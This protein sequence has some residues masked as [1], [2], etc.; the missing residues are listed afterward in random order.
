M[1]QARDILLSTINEGRPLVLVLGHDAWRESVVGDPVLSLALDHLKSP[2][3]SS[4]GWYAIF[5]EKALPHTF[6]DW[7]SE[8][9]ERRVHPNWFATL[10][11]VPWSAIFTSTLDPTFRKAL[12]R[13]GREPE[14][15]LTS[16]EKPRAV[17]SQAR[18]PLYYLFSHAGSHDPAALPPRTYGDFSAR[19]AAHAIP[20]LNRVMPTATSLGTVVIEGFISGSDWVRI[21]ELL[22]TLGRTAKGQILWFGGEPKN[23]SGQDSYVFR[24]AVKAGQ[25]IVEQTRLGTTLAALQA[26]NS[27]SNIDVPTWREPGIVS[28]R[29]G[30]YLETKPDERLRVEAVASIVDDSWTG[31]LHPLEPDTKYDSF[32]RFHGGL[33]G[34]RL[35]VEG[36]L[37]NFSIRRD[38][39]DKLLS[40]V[41]SAIE[42]HAHFDSPIIVHGQSG[43]G[44]SVALARS[45]AHVR[46]NRSA[47]VL[48][49][50]NRVPQAQEVAN[51]CER[52]ERAGAAVTLIVCDTNRSVDLYQDLFISLRSSGR[53]VVLV[54]SRYRILASEEA[55]QYSVE[56]EPELS[57]RERSELAKLIGNY[58]DRRVDANSLNNTT[59]FAFLYRYLPSTRPR[60]G[61]G[62]GKEARFTEEKIRARGRISHPVPSTTEIARQLIELGLAT[63]Y[64]PLFSKTTSSDQVDNPA[65]LLV[66]LVMVAGRLNCSVPLGLL[67]RTVV[68]SHAGIDRT[69]IVE[70]FADLDL[71]RWSWAD[72]EHSD[73][74]V[75]PRLALEA[76]LICDRRLGNR[77]R[78]A[79]CLVLLISG[80]RGS[81]LESDCEIR[82]LVDLLQQIGESGPTG[83]R[84]HR[85]YVKVSR[86]LT[87]LRTNGILHPSLVLQES[88]FRRAAIRSQVVTDDESLPLLEEARDA[89]QSTLEQV[90]NG[91]LLAGRRTYEFLLVER[92]SLYGYLASDHARR[93]KNADE[94][95]SAYSAARTAIRKASN[96]TNHYYP[97]DV[98]LWTPLDLLEKG[99]LSDL[100]QADLRADIYATVD[101]VDTKMLP[102]SQKE[103]FGRRRMQLGKVLD[104]STLSETAYQELMESGS[105]AGFF[106]RAREFLPA[107][108]GDNLVYDKIQISQAREGAE[109]LRGHFDAIKHDERC[110]YLL[111]ECCWIAEMGRRPLRGERQ[112]LPASDAARQNMLSIVRDLNYAADGMGSHSGRYLE[113]V[114][115]WCVGN[116]PVA[117]DM[118][119]SLSHETENL[120]PRRVVRRHIIS[121]EKFSPVAFRGRVERRLSP[122]RASVRVESLNCLVNIHSRDFAAEDLERGREVRNFSI[123]FNFIGAIAE[124]MR[125]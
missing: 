49:A 50:T 37:R 67:I 96:V 100:Q 74:L 114:L 69:T 121:D 71:F 1:E 84:Y 101:Q 10:A 73:F 93:G 89:V 122:N 17:R 53:R 78:E 94:I 118:F 35:L 26:L 66:D 91:S 112:P 70:M 46:K 115:N 123:A 86:A 116:V 98:G 45:V 124:P 111:L 42:D 31:F 20:M 23:L 48:Y 9:F 72:F 47:A 39:E 22:G 12:H 60:F 82:F 97:L 18:P 30:R 81:D 25:I 33:G 7:L 107:L 64:K 41:D 27:L 21:D 5:S 92:A 87:A 43:T 125:K 15:I 51:F 4:S 105:T 109:F 61:T 2:E 65:G 52:A 120:D 28:F 119:T 75:S 11:D 55:T 57:P 76:E 36:I 88:A 8:R 117:K 24:E 103:K 6:Y 29:D 16:T 108:N 99:T 3:S 62:L 40:L 102:A 32:R 77:E 59:I 34:P 110:M 83:P 68:D 54:G 44:K 104:D 13:Q 79:E 14:P 113:A 63:R 38:F 19:K 95:W 56:A 106:L 58:S 80:V 90:D 85:S